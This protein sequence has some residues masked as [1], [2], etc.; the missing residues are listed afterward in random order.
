[1]N[2]DQ[3]FDVYVQDMLRGKVMASIPYFNQKEIVHMLDRIYAMDAGSRS[4]YDQILMA[5]LSMCVIHQGFG[6]EC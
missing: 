3:T 4:A 2:P 5:L 6:M 1:M